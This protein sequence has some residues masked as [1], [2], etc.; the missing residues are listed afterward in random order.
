M[1]NDEQRFMDWCQRNNIP[2]PGTTSALCLAWVQ[3]AREEREACAKGC[4]SEDWDDDAK[5]YGGL[6]ANEIRARG[7]A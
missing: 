3:S 1:N 7:A 2:W 5:Y 6:M 4:E